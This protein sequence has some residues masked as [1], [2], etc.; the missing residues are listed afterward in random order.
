MER[1]VNTA[2]GTKKALNSVIALKKRFL[3]SESAKS[4]KAYMSLRAGTLAFAI[5]LYYFIENGTLGLFPERW[6][7]IYRNMRVSDILLYGLIGY[8][9]YNI[10]EF[11]DLFKSK[12]F[13]IAKIFLGYLLL[14]FGLSAIRYH[15]DVVEY[16]FRLKGIWSSFLILPFMLLLKRGGLMALIKIVLPVAIISNIL[17]ILT[18]LTGQPFLPDVSIITQRLPWGMTVYR[19]YGGTFNG[20]LYL[21]GFMYFWIAKR[22]KLYQ[23]FLAI[24]F[25]TP[26]ILAFGRTAWISIVFAIVGM[27]IINWLK[28]RNFAIFFRQIFI[29]FIFMVS[30]IIAFIKFIPESDYYVDAIRAR[31]FQGVEDVKYSEGTYDTRVHFQNDALLKLWSQTNPFIGVGMH[32]MWVVRPENHEEQVWYNA[33][34]DVTWPAVLAA[35]GLIGFALALLYQFYCM[36]MSYKLISKLREINILTFFLTFAFIKL[37]FDTFVCYSYALTSVGLWGFNFLNF[38]TAAFVYC[39]EKYKQEKK[40]DELQEIKENATMNNNNNGKSSNLPLLRKILQ[41]N[42]FFPNQKNGSDKW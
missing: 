1:I 7:M 31:I 35:Y 26:H 11:S 14:E 13:L 15:F 29:V 40:E 10:R 25:L 4:A 9:L 30:S 37:V 5:F 34:C 12:S 41:N 21:F 16:F 38:Y 3:Y 32:P 8:S 22:F 19:V 20:E 39:Y 18:A 33:F 42:H 6:Y 27:I 2:Y 28:Q 36:G 23:L 24:L 17:Y